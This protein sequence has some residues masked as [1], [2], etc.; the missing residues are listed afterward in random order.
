[1]PNSLIRSTNKA[2]IINRELRWW[3]HLNYKVI[4]LLRSPKSQPLIYW[5]EKDGVYLND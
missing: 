4:V 1:M 2:E 3:R 5:W